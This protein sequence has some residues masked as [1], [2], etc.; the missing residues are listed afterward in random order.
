MNSFSDSTKTFFKAPS[1]RTAPFNWL[2]R[3]CFHFSNGPRM[4]GLK[5]AQD[6][7]CRVLQ[8]CIRLVELTSC[9]ASQLTELV[10]IRHLR[11][12]RKYQI[13]AHCSILLIQ[14]RAR[15]AFLAP[16]GATGEAIQS[17]AAPNIRIH[18]LDARFCG[19]SSKN[20]DAASRILKPAICRLGDS[21][22]SL[23]N[24]GTRHFRLRQSFK[25][26]PGGHQRRASTHRLDAGNCPMGTLT[27]TTQSALYGWLS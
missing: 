18:F 13:R 7:V 10:A 12:C 3:R 26:T 19:S 24:A 27:H 14:F 25:N 1:G 11:Q 4:G 22:C 8:P 6:F 17:R 21:D 23:E 15:L 20:F 2:G 9:L 16:T 5:T